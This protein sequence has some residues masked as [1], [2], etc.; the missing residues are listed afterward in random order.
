VHAGELRLQTRSGYVILTAFPLQQWL[1]EGASLTRY[2]YSVCVVYDTTINLART[3]FSCC[4]VIQKQN[5][6]VSLILALRLIGQAFIY[7]LY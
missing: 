7:E 2:T 3:K 1:K 6:Y 4:Y 5:S